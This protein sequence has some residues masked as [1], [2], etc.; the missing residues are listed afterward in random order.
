MDNTG[1]QKAFD[2]Y[3]EAYTKLSIS[4]KKKEF[5]EKLR[6]IISGIGQVNQKLGRNHDLLINRELVDLKSDET[7]EKD[8]LEGAFVYIHTIEDSIF[9][10]LDYLLKTDN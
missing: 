6:D 4:D 7:S 10:L 8:F 9:D 1:L 2:E 5:I 3:I